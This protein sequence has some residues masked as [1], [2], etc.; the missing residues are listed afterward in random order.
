MPMGQAPVLMRIDAHAGVRALLG[1]IEPFLRCQRVIVVGSGPTVHED[2][3]R[4]QPR[5]T[6]KIIAVNGGA[7]ACP[8]I[9]VLV[10]N[11]RDY[12]NGTPTDATLWTDARWELHRRMLAQMVGRHVPV[13]VLLMRDTE[14]QTR[15]RLAAQGVTWDTAI[16]VSPSDRI[17][18]AQSVG[19]KDYETAFQLSSGVI[20]WALAV[21][22]NADTVETAGIGMTPGYHYLDTLPDEFPTRRHATSDQEAIAWLSQIR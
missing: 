8:R 14:E 2:L 16:H 18:I 1:Q 12:R 3:E 19:V 10:T 17:Q 7:S 22:C 15:D 5:E 6:D 9:D 11:G 13:L 20:A 4:L 21:A